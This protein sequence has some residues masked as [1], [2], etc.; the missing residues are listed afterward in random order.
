MRTNKRAFPLPLAA[1][2]IAVSLFFL[3]SLKVP[4][5]V[6]SYLG[7][8][9]N[10]T[11]LAVGIFVLL[12]AVLLA[13]T[14]LAM[15]KNRHWKYLAI[16]M[17][18]NLLYLLPYVLHGRWYQLIQYLVLMVPFSLCAYLVVGAKDGAQQFFHCLQNISKVIFAFFALYI[19][20]LFVAKP[21]EY[22]IVEI[23][24]MSYGDIAYA[25]LP[26]LFADLELFLTPKAG[27]KRFAGAR[28]LIY[29]ATVIYSGTRSAMICM[30]AAFALQLIRHFP[31]IKSAKKTHTAI[32]ALALV[33]CVLFCNNVTPT[34]SRL[35][36][37]KD[38]LLYD[39]GEKDFSDIFADPPDKPK[40]TTPSGEEADD[41]AEFTPPVGEVP[42]KWPA[43][44]TLIFNIETRRFEPIDTAF[45]YYILKNEC[46]ISETE[47]LL[48]ED[49]KEGTGK[50]LYAEETYRPTAASYSLPHNF[51]VYLWSTAWGEFTSAKLL[52]KGCLHY[53]IKYEE[54]FPHNV[55]LELLADFGVVGFVLFFAVT[56]FCFVYLLLNAHKT[57]K[58]TKSAML[59]FI[60]MY[61]PMF[62][63]FHSLYFN[64]VLFFA[65]CYMILG[66]VQLLEK[67]TQKI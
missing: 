34:G 40:E 52:G 66:T 18:L 13:A 11:L 20:V 33:A 3:G 29:T 21:G 42:Q 5:M 63:L 41:F 44:V 54:T 37:V 27:Q 48:R 55:V 60:F 43:N 28:I 47:E 6:L 45:Q 51:R 7:I 67:R 36:V 62:L 32:C 26:F 59:A 65:V 35:N 50:Y 57:R 17:A 53:Q 19:L 30:V 49:L 9:E 4:K 64:G 38:N 14:V 8:S 23:R 10:T 56:I 2:Y 31:Y 15:A 46:T 58:K 16:L 22:G 24:E 25:A 1:M 61:I 12:D 39:M